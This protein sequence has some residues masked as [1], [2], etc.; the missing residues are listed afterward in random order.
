MEGGIEGWL[1]NPS[2]SPEPDPLD[3]WG[4]W[5]SSYNYV[6]STTSLYT[7]PRGFPLHKN[8][9]GIIRPNSVLVRGEPKPVQYGNA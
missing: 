9:L 1:G 3:V 2:L 8:S 5:A 6:F 4:G 7:R